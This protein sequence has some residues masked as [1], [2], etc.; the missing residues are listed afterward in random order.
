MYKRNKRKPI[1][2]TFIAIAALLVLL[3]GLSVAKRMGVFSKKAAPLPE[4][5]THEILVYKSVGGSVTI[6][7]AGE[8][9]EDDDQVRMQAAEDEMITMLVTPV[10]GKVFENLTIN[11]ADNITQ[12]ERY[13]VNDAKGNAKRINFVMPHCDIILNF[14]FQDEDAPEE[15]TQAQTESEQQTEK[16]SPY[17][18]RLHGLTAQIIA[19]YNGQFDDEKFLQQLGDDLQMS[20][21]AS[22]Y[23][24]V[25]D[26][27]FSEQ[28][29]A[30]PEESDKVFHYIYFNYDKE[31]KMLSTYY[32]RENE[33]VF[34][35]PPE[36]DNTSETETETGS[37]PSSQNGLEQSTSIGNGSTTAVT[38]GSGTGYTGGN[39][40]GYTEE[41]SESEVAFDIMQVSKTFLKFVGG[42]DEFY[43]Q[44][45]QYVL[46]KGLN[47]HIVGTM[48][49][50]EILPEKN[51]ATFTITLSNGGAI[52]GSY[53]KSSG[54]FS[55]KGL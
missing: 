19:S 9:E 33:F 7:H 17:G 35:L 8:I 41:G 47:G 43:E 25:K 31:W 27:T 48:S 38:S 36:D 23:K 37:T 44:A 1:I 26:V 12:E 29:Y 49:S 15:E 11:D 34:S 5:V 30:G 16:D 54:A 2:I 13:L 24:T 32:K 6:D 46:L 14:S 3:I 45:F 51:T 28:D 39:G 21:P 52:K 18:L 50:Y 22:E 40:G 4:K 55:F 53:D 42:E 10:S 20:S